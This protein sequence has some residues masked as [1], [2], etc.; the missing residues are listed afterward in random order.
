MNGIPLGCQATINAGLGKVARLGMAV[1]I[2][3]TGMYM[4]VNFFLVGARGCAMID[5]RLGVLLEVQ[6]LL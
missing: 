5:W 3:F 2:S 4:Y 1:L 6:K